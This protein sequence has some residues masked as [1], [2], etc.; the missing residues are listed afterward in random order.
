MQRSDP[1]SGEVDT[2]VEPG[3]FRS[4]VDD[5]QTI[6]FSPVSLPLSDGEPAGGRRPVTERES[7]H[8]NDL[9]R[10][11]RAPCHA[12][13]FERRR[14]NPTHLPDVRWSR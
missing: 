13:R 1:T 6:G 7:G 14:Q 9:R 11:S 8:R 3:C 10:R 2:A 12:V 4:V 5:H